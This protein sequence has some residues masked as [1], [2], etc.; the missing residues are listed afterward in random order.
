MI[1]YS[2]TFQLTDLFYILL[3]S[4]T[5]TKNATIIMRWGPVFDKIGGVSVLH[6]YSGYFQADPLP[7]LLNLFFHF[8]VSN[9]CIFPSDKI[10][11]PLANTQSV[12]LQVNQSIYIPTMISHRINFVASIFIPNIINHWNR[13]EP[14]SMTF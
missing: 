2:S 13:K 4:L 11:Y 7:V 3:Y 10:N 12:S 8:F 14:R 9:S 1:Q 5:V 6:T